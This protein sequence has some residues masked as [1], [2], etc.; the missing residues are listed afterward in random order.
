VIVIIEPFCKKM[1]HE[2]INSGF[3]TGI[4]LSYP[5]EEVQLYAHK[6]HIEALINILDHDKV[7]INNVTFVEIINAPNTG[8]ISLVAYTYIFYKIFNDLINREI[9]KVFFLSFSPAILL[10]IKKLKMIN[11][12]SGLNFLFILHGAFEEIAGNGNNQLYISKINSLR[13]V[14]KLIYQYYLDLINL[15]WNYI[16]KRHFSFLKV[17]KYNHDKDFRYVALSPHIIRNA[18]IFL[19]VDYYNIHLINFPINFQKENI[20]LESEYMKIAVFGYGNSKKLSDISKLLV[21]ENISDKF[22]IKIIGMDN[23]GLSDFPF[24]KFTSNGQPLTRFEMEKE[25]KDV[26]IFLILYESNGY[27]LSCSGSIFEALSYCKPII[28]LQNECID[29]Y[30]NSD[31]PIGISCKSDYD[32]AITLKN[33]IENNDNERSR[34]IEF[35]KNI[36]TLRDRLDIKHSIE[37]IKNAYTW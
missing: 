2:K 13:E 18:R 19:D 31:L 27:R 32:L 15:P 21:E 9:K 11:K 25:A 35:R 20:L 3:L 34:L 6:S 37:Q 33:I 24:I 36:L 22:E 12:F 4:R 16:S 28:H 26:D 23:R 8:I 5:D 17:F 1:S 7:D 30:N 14:F 29:Y 10:I